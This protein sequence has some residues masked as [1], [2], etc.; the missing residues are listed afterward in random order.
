L[1][2]RCRTESVEEVLLDGL[3]GRDFE[4]LSPVISGQATLHPA[5]KDVDVIIEGF[6]EQVK[7]D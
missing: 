1:T 5:V 7:E 3:C 6:K 2:S 4:K